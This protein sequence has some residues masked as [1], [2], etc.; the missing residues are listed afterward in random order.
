MIP[1]RWLE[2]MVN[3]FRSDW[4]GEVQYLP[5]YPNPV[6]GGL[7]HAGP[8]DHLQEVPLLMY[9]PGY[10]KP[11][12]Y[13]QPVDI[14]DIAPTSA[15]LVKFDDEVPDGEAL[16]QVLVPEADRPMPKLVVTLVWDSAGIDVGPSGRTT[17]R[18]Y[19]P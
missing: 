14:T 2:R 6:D 15:R 13:K 4:S 5:Q 18:T 7:S 17:G 10:V 16:T 11:G 9:G 1:H 12:V 8:W 3:T 19:A